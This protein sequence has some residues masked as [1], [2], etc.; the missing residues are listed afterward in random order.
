MMPLL[1][2]PPDQHAAD[3]G[4]ADTATVD[5]AAT[6]ESILNVYAD[7]GLVSPQAQSVPQA[8]IKMEHIWRGKLH[9]LCRLRFNNHFLPDNGDGRAMLTAFLRFGLTDESAIEH[10]PWLDQAELRKLQRKAKYMKWRKVGALIR[11]T[12]AERETCKLWILD[13]CDVSPEEVKRR[14]DEKRK[15]RDKDWRKRKREEQRKERE[16]MRAAN[17]RGDAMLQMLDMG[18]RAFPRK[19][20]IAPPRFYGDWMLVSALV[21]LAKLSRAFRRPDGSPLRNMRQTVHRVI[22]QL[23]DTGMVDTMRAPG[24]RG[25]ILLVKK[26]AEKPANAGKTDAVCDRHSVTSDFPAKDVGTQR[27]A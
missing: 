4:H 1:P 7:F 6:N 5:A 8:T 9:K 23:V 25:T 18:E 13:P 16:K 21:E 14:Q 26:A 2:T 20:G 3:V 11:L 12:Y 17:D 10:A 15:T 22:K 24:K 19:P 27:V